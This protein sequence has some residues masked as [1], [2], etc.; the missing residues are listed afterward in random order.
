[1]QYCDLW[2]MEPGALRQMQAL[3]G[4]FT[5]E[6]VEAAHESLETVRQAGSPH[7][8]EK[9]V[10]VIPVHGALEA[11]PTLMGMLFG[12]TSYEAVGNALDVLVADDSVSSIVMDFMTPGGMVYGCS[13]LA[14]KIYSA[15]GTKPIL[16]VANPMAA[17]GGFW[18]AAACDRVVASPSADVGSVGVICSRF[19]AT[20]QMEREG[21]KEHV[22]RS[23]GAPFKGELSDAEPLTDDGKRHLQAR[24]DAI[25][26]VFHS[27]LAKFRG[28]N[29][30]HVRDHFG[31]GRLVDAKAAVGA[32]MIDRVMT[33]EETV[34][35][36]AA[37][38][39]RIAR[40]AAQDDWDA[41]TR[42]ESL[43]FRAEQV[44]AMVEAN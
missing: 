1:M 13:E 41:P 9:S 18:T 32:G 12:M 30:Q 25:E 4:R 16:A 19:D 3:S 33:L 14:N 35:K 37:G 8:R 31:K 20:A 34:G 42:Q 2:V 7:R 5:A 29:V 43:R 28:V 26:S 38:R 44:R 24:A 17:S 21:V 22:I 36:L 10:A 11:R 23:S 15:R 6:A 39:I 27:D 40:E